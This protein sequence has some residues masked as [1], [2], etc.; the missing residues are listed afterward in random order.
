MATTP[1]ATLVGNPPASPAPTTTITQ[2][3]EAE[4]STIK[5]TRTKT[6]TK[7]MV[8]KSFKLGHHFTTYPKKRKR[9]VRGG[10]RKVKCR[11]N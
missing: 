11:N 3:I 6:P 10:L 1:P 9:C 5:R 2:K 4:A 8:L 7:R